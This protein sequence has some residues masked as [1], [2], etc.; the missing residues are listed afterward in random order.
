MAEQNRIPYA[1][2]AHPNDNGHLSLAETERMAASA[3]RPL[4]FPR[5]SIS[6]LAF[7]TNFSFA[8]SARISD[9]LSG[10]RSRF[11]RCSSQR[12]TI[13]RFLALIL[14]AYVHAIPPVTRSSVTVLVRIEGAIHAFLVECLSAN[15]ASIDV[16]WP[17][18]SGSGCT[19]HAWHA[20]HRGLRRDSR[21]TRRSQFNH[22][23]RHEHLRSYGRPLHSVH[24]IGTMLS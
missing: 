23:T 5:I 9:F 7:K 12:R 21:R 4:R 11:P 15:R 14:R 24:A 10:N 20:L 3:L 2:T 19:P 8:P 18:M 22:V 17:L 1:K 16:G 13:T 6:P